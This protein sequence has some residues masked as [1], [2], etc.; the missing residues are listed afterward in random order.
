MSLHSALGDLI[1]TMPDGS[2][3]AIPV[4]VIALHRAT[5]FAKSGDFVDL[6]S[7]LELDT[8]PLF[9]TH[10]HAVIAWAGGKMR[11][12]DV[13]A[14]AYLLNPPPRPDYEKGWIHGT[15]RLDRPL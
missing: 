7:S 10:A 11:W 2:E 6:T 13:Q 1:V 15:K 9:R 5:Y 3:W 14:S 4:A 8:L 12:S